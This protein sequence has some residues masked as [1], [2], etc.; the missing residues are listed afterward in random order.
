MLEEFQVGEPTVSNKIAVDRH[1]RWSIE[2]GKSEMGKIMLLALTQLFI[3]P[4]ESTF[5]NEDKFIPVKRVR[6]Y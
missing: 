3:D 2:M 6:T 5:I 4:S 1:V